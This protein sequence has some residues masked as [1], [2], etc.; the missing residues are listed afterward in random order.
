MQPVRHSRS[1]GSASHAKLAEDP[2]D[3]HAGRLLG[4]EQRR[5]DLTVGRALGQESQH[6]TFTRGEPE[7]IIA[8]GRAVAI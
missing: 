4:H 7:R 6:L 3:V 2:R 1:L 5:P 8:R